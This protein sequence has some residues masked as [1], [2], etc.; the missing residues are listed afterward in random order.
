MNTV[1]PKQ[2]LADWC[3]EDGHEGCA[4]VI[5]ESPD[6]ML[7]SALYWVSK[8]LASHRVYDDDEA[9]ILPVILRD[10]AEARNRRSLLTSTNL[11]TLLA[12]GSLLALTAHLDYLWA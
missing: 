8:H 6:W 7:P 11:L 4:T 1:F 10:E 12:V 2:Q 9:R 5:E 3:R